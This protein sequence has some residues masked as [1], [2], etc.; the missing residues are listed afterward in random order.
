MREFEN[1]EDELLTDDDIEYITA[2]SVWMKSKALKT[3]SK[4]FLN[5]K[6]YEIKYT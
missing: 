5:K 6:H 4:Y 2:A 1:L 3:E